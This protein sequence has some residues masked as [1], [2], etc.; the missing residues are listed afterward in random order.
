[1]TQ[2]INFQRLPRIKYNSEEIT[3]MTYEYFEYLVLAFW[4]ETK[5]I[6]SKEEFVALATN[7]AMRQV[8]LNNV[9]DICINK[10]REV[11]RGI[12]NEEVQE[13]YEAHRNNYSN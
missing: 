6:V 7:I 3:N 2:Q 11:I 13:V 9:E 5:S 4:Y 8:K 1:M 12:I 10:V